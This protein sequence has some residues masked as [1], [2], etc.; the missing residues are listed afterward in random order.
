M[1]W[2]LANNAPV[3]DN[4]DWFCAMQ[5][6]WDKRKSEDA[7]LPEYRG[8]RYLD[9]LV[10]NG[11]EWLHPYRDV[12]AV[13]GYGNHETA[14]LKHHETDLTERLV[15]KLRS[16]GAPRLVKGRFAYWIVYK[17]W[18][19]DKAHKTLRQFNHHGWGGGGP[20]TR[21]TIDTARMAVYL[22]DADIVATGHVH[23]H[24]EMAIERHR[25]NNH[26]RTYQ[27]TQ[28]HIRTPGY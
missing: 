27:D 18:F 13:M 19:S 7:M 28:L 1:D 9:K 24:Y 2:A 20:V 5:G 11:A 8:G 4:G 16:E 23:H 15:Y 22:P 25:I 21:G 17:F 26:N 3:I 10:D 14:I 12:L 6:K